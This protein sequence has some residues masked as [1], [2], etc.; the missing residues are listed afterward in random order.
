VINEAVASTQF[1]RSLVGDSPYSSITLAIVEGNSPGGHSPAHVAAIRRQAANA[2]RPFR[3]D[4]A[5]VDE[6]PE[7]SQAHVIAH[8]W[9]GQ[10]VGWKTYHDQWLSEGF[11]QYFAALYVA[12]H[13]GESAFH[14]VM[15]QMRK[16]GMEQ[17]AQGPLFLGYRIGHVRDDGRAFRAVVYDKGAAVLHM[18]RQL[19]G[20][21]A[22]FLGVRR[23]YAD[24]RFEKAGTEDLRL[25]MEKES[26]RSLER[27]FERWV[28]GSTLPQL[29]LSYKEQD[30]AGGGREL[31]LKVEQ[32]G[33]LFDVPVVLLLQYS[34]KPPAEV[35]VPV[36]EKLTEVRLPITGALRRVEV[37][38]DDGTLAEIRKQ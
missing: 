3:N 17:T 31:M 16:W 5:T 6:Y 37:S 32:S 24:W 26:G 36:S 29:T 7:F 25:A 35:I 33:E 14:V 21:E 30:A 12:D 22:F 11:A 13:R 2:P 4:P 23:F 10:A 20:D 27:F 1:F 28:Y 38:K 15:R 18:L 34:D 9:W 8:Q 19:I